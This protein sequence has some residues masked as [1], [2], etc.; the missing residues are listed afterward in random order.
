V[1]I[2]R[3]TWSVRGDVDLEPQTWRS[4]WSARLDVGLESGFGSPLVVGKGA[5][6]AVRADRVEE[7]R[8]GEEQ[9]GKWA[10]AIDKKDACGYNWSAFLTIAQRRVAA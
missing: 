5:D 9:P 6:R 2:W 3:S 4:A 10:S 1:R 8:D 7:G